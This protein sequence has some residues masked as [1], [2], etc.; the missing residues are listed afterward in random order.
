M[1]TLDVRTLTVPVGALRMLEVVLTC[2]SFSLAASA[3]HN[4]SSYWAWSMFTW[5]FCCF[6]TLLP[7]TLLFFP[8]SSSSPPSSSSL[9]LLPTPDRK[10]TR[11]NSSH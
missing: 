2:I 3:G 5:C 7:P 8:T 6:F 1:V 9:L 4:S 11:L 10:S